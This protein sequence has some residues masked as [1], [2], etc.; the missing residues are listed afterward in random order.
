M[1]E[2]PQEIRDF[3]AVLGFEEIPIED[4]L[5]ALSFEESPEGEYV[6]VTDE[7]GVLPQSLD[8]PLLLACYSA[9]GAFQW[10]TGFKNA[11]Q[12]RDIWAPGQTYAKKMQAAAHHREELTSSSPSKK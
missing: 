4:G 6:L 8:N 10:S 11:D 12:F 1:E 9:E 5:T 2:L 3:F 7:D